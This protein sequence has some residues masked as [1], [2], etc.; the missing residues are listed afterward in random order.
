M[1]QRPYE[2]DDEYYARLDRMDAAARASDTDPENLA[3]DEFLQLPMGARLA[4]GGSD[5]I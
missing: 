4:E 2:T 1:N 3:T 5:D